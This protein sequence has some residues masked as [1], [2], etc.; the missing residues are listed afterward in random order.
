MSSQ[1]GRRQEA[2]CF[3]LLSEENKAAEVKQSEP[4]GRGDNRGLLQRELFPRMG[5]THGAIMVIEAGS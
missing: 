1:L 3:Q 5:A 2:I 4:E